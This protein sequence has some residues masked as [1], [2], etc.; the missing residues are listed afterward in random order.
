MELRR[1]FTIENGFDLGIAQGLQ[2]VGA[3]L[4][5]KFAF[6]LILEPSSFKVLMEDASFNFIPYSLFE[7]KIQDSFSW[8]DFKHKKGFIWI[9]ILVQ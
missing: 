6:D 8:R 9:Q 7:F 5:F 1:S 3:I 4:K 2:A